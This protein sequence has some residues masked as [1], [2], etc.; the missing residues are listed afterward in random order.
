M[1]MD[2]K[3]VIATEHHNWAAQQVEP[4]RI[5]TIYYKWIWRNDSIVCRHW[6]T[7][8][9]KLRMNDP[10]WGFWA[11]VVVWEKKRNESRLNCIINSIS[12]LKIIK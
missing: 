12:G 1:Y 4:G 2:G 11:Y 3:K 6:S 5:G 9:K 10:G 8:K 7:H